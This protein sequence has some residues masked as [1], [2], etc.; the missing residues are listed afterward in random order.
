MKKINP[1]FVYDER[2]KK[3]GVILA[4]EEFEKCIDVLEDYQDYVL[5]KQRSVKKEKLILTILVRMLCNVF[6]YGCFKRVF[7]IAFS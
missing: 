5:A 6:F 1:Q 3:I 4:I 7:K 2:G